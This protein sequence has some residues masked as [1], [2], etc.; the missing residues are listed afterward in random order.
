M[1]M[2][3]RVI[4]EVE[5]DVGRLARDDGQAFIEGIRVARQGEQP[6]RFFGEGLANGLARISGT[7]PIGGHALAPSVGLIVEISEIGKRAAGEECVACKS[8]GPL[9]PTL[10]IPPRNG[11]GAGLKAIVRGECEQY[12]MKADGIAVPLKYDTLEIVVEQYPRQS[13]PAREGL[14]VAAQKVLEALAEEET[15]EEL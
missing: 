14:D 13:S 5:A 3:D 12:R 1:R 6:R 15:Q 4:I 8:H 10:L 11:D 7:A 2:W 9:H